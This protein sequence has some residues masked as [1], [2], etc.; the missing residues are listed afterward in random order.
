MYM[1]Q[2]GMFHIL[3]LPIQR[4]KVQKQH[5]FLIPLISRTILQHIGL[6]GSHQNLELILVI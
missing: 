1:V 6:K 3:E 4:L 5:T 2:E